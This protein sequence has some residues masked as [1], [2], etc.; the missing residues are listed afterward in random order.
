[1]SEENVPAKAEEM[2]KDEPTKD[3]TGMKSPDMRSNQDGPRS[4]SL[5]NSNSK[6]MMTG[7]PGVYS[8]MLMT[9]MGSLGV[10]G[11]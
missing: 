9:G 6:F 10:D 5:N 1:M 4:D 11:A 2:K 8:K 3:S 7:G